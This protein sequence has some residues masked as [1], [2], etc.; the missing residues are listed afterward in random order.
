MLRAAPQIATTPPCLAI[1]RRR[2]AAGLLAGVAA[3]GWLGACAAPGP[4]PTS[5][6]VRE[7][8]GGNRAAAFDSAEAA[9]IGLGYS[10]E[11][12]DPTSGV[13]VTEPLAVSSAEE[14]AVRSGGR[15]RAP[16]G[17]RRVAEVRVS[18]SGG[19]VQVYCKV[20]VQE[21]TTEAHRFFAQNSAL[22]DNPGATAIDRDAGTTTRQN[23]VWQT[24]RRDRQAEQA[25]LARITESSEARGRAAPSG[26]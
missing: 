8:A 16:R 21:Q 10:I 3:C 15:L 7:V 12:R 1:R 25:I 26:R 4:A 6:G 20:A 5:F 19:A 22:S 23:T 9:L 11:R 18:G 14:P 17:L 13:L 24:L 2:A